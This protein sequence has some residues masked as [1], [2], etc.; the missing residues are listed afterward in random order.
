MQKVLEYFS[1][2][3][4]WDAMWNRRTIE[5]ELEACDIHRP[6]RDLFLSYLPIGGKIVEAGCGLGKWVIYLNQRGY[7]ILGID[8]NELAV[9]NLRDY[10]GS[11]RVELGDILDIHY[12]DSSFDAY[13]SLG[14]V[15]HFEEGPLTA[16]KEAYRVLKPNG[17]IF[18]SVPTVNVLRRIIRRPARRAINAFSMSLV[19]LLSGWRQSKRGAI[20]AAM[21]TITGALPERV[22]DVILRR[23]RSQYH[24]IE[25]R[26]SRSELESFLRQSGFEVIK[27][28]PDDF[29]GSKDHAVGLVVD[30]PF[31]GA[32]N[33][34]NFR[35]NHLGNLTSRLLLRISPWI[36]CAQVLCIAKSQKTKPDASDGQL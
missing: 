32:Q 30:F 4:L 27:T 2:S 11:L 9:A 22:L 6:L 33:A 29:Y 34:V 14:V 7:D 1:Q 10:D 20:L 35:L 17:V 16:L 25:Y 3:N 31:L 8:N 15:E 24:F 21:R 19:I 23:K 12:P 28:A 18:V 13:I 36:A 26:Y 5:Q